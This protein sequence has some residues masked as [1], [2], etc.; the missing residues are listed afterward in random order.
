MPSP[1]DG[2]TTDPNGLYPSDRTNGSMPAYVDK[3]VDLGTSVVV[4]YSDGT[5]KVLPKAQF[6]PQPSQSSGLSPVDIQLKAKQ[7][8][9]RQQDAAQLAEQQRQFN[10]KFGL[11]KARGDQQQ[12]V[13][14]GQLSGYY[15]GS[16]TLARDQ[17]GE[18][19][20]QF[21][22]TSA[23]NYY[24]QLIDTASNPRNF[25]ANFF[26]RRGAP[27]PPNVADYGTGLKPSDIVPFPQFLAQ[28]MGQ[29]G[30]PQRLPSQPVNQGMDHT[31]DLPRGGPMV[32]PQRMGGGLPALP[33]GLKPGVNP[34][35]SLLPAAAPQAAQI[36]QA[37]TTQATGVVNPNNPA[38]QQ[39][40]YMQGGKAIGQ[41]PDLGQNVNYAAA[42][43]D[44]ANTQAGITNIGGHTFYD[45]AADSRVPAYK[46]G[47]SIMLTAPH[48]LVNALTG[49]KTALAGEA[50]P[51]KVTFSG[52]AIADPLGD[53]G[54]DPYYVNDPGTDPYAGFADPNYNPAN[55]LPAIPESWTVQGPTGTY[56]S[57]D[58]PS[59]PESHTV[60]D[61][62]GTTA[63][64][65]PAVY[66]GGADQVAITNGSQPAPSPVV[67][68]P[69]NTAPAPVA[70][71]AP[72]ADNVPDPQVSIAPIV[73][74]GAIPSGGGAA[75]PAS[76]V[77]SR[78][79][80]AAPGGGFNPS[81]LLPQ[82]VR[83]P[84][85][86]PQASNNYNSG[87]TS[88]G[89]APGSV[90]P[91]GTF[92]PSG[93]NSYL[94]TFLPGE[95]STLAALN[96]AGAVPPFLSRLFAQSQGAQEY[97]TNQPQTN[98]LPSEVPLVSKIAFTQMAPSE[99]QALLSYVSSYGITPEDYIAYIEQNSP[100]GGSTQLPTLGN[101]FQY[102][103]Q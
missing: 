26:Q 25:V 11:D 51:E 32:D 18:N 27:T 22:T 64:A 39:A 55:G 5:T 50:G 84:L 72:P 75:A 19:A 13:S 43:Q 38:L 28:Y 45:P 101:P 81:S 62:T 35:A 33:P 80:P 31:Y 71:A 56:A 37:P 86:L 2:L 7:D 82:F 30:Q 94:P 4:F 10:E 79:D 42:G 34:F 76:S 83:Q 95:D 74:P 66:A 57:Y 98:S 90:A 41:A 1:Y 92:N 47:G 29:G 65:G 44:F 103:R 49:A 58:Q 68:A 48:F 100:H 96:A 67:A 20:R 3:T 61:P 69:S 52:K 24:K 59:T 88:T 102:A 89:L 87:V 91:A 85:G 99:Q 40:N 93:A 77:Q 6:A 97:G 54:N 63:A 9:Q 16:P 23:F 14:Q 8:F 78:P 53:Y 17:L 46:N 70:P 12:Q 73:Q 15:N 36:P 21:D 60:S